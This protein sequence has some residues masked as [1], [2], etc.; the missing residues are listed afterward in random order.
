LIERDVGVEF[1]FVAFTIGGVV[2]NEVELAA[3]GPVDSPL[4]EWLP[5]GCRNREHRPAEHRDGC[6]EEQNDRLHPSGCADRM[7]PAY[8]RLGHFVTGVRTPSNGLDR[9]AVPP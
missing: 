9:A 4:P 8:S 2:I 5:R 7:N 1:V 6:G 3:Y